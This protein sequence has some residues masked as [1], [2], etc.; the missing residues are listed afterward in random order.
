MCNQTRYPLEMTW[1]QTWHYIA[2]LPTETQNAMGK[3][4]DVD[5]CQWIGRASV[6]V[7]TEVLQFAPSALVAS[8]ARRGKISRQVIRAV[9]AA[10]FK[11]S[12]RRTNTR[13]K[14][15]PARVLSVGASD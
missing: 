13:G 3:A 12:A 14:S 5:L 1:R 10:N 9:S 11:P 7:A 2:G 8:L 15:S 4:L 6:E